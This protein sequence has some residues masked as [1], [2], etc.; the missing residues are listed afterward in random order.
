[1]ILSFFFERFPAFEDRI[2]SEALYLKK[3]YIC[4]LQLQLI[5]RTF[6]TD[7]N[8]LDNLAQFWDIKYRKQKNYGQT[9]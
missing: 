9:R 7:K 4:W 2:N 8:I 3:L 1:M 6:I 5:G